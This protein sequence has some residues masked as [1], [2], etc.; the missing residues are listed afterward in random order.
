VIGG[1]VAG[2]TA[3]LSLLEAGRPCVL[4]EASARVG[5]CCATIT[6]AGQTF[7]PA[8]SVVIGKQMLADVLD[9][10]GV[11]IRPLLRPMQPIVRAQWPSGQFDL[12]GPPDEFA[13]SLSGFADADIPRIP[14]FLDRC[15]GVAGRILPALWQW[16]M[17]TGPTALA[18]SIPLAPWLLKSYRSLIR[19]SFGN[20]RLCFVLEAFSD[21]YAGLPAAQAPAFLGTVPALS[22]A[23]GCFEVE[24]GIQRLPEHLSACVQARGGTIRLGEPALRLLVDGDRVTGVE[25][26]A[27]VTWVAGAIAACDI[28]R[29]VALLPRSPRL[30]GTN[31]HIGAL[32]PGV[33]VMSIVATEDGDSGLPP[34]TWVLPEDEKTAATSGEPACDGVGLLPLAAVTRG[35]GKAGERGIRIGGALRA[36]VPLSAAQVD[37]CADRLLRFVEESGLR[38]RLRDVQIW[39]PTDYEFTLGLPF[40]SAFSF[41]P[42]RWQLGP[43]RYGPRTPLSN[44]TVAG[45]SCFPGFGIPLVAFSGKLSATAL[46]GSRA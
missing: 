2:L 25:T 41:A 32:R 20:G 8:A 35:H 11:D 4:F 6:R 13:R 16:K 9:P 17:G 15:M 40:G 24:G 33:A 39:S 7:E 37:D 34:I 27:G 28:R 5:G 3:A 12:T 46:L 38:P 26:P 43:T 23:E 19:T 14:R 42:S 18:A 29:T 31:L 21:F 1:G 22:I 30:F 45:Q 36:G 44:L 10:L